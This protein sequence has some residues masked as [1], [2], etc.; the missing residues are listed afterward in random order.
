[1]RR[2]FIPATVVTAVLATAAA[3][4]AAVRT[5]STVYYCTSNN[6]SV[7]TVALEPPPGPV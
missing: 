5:V 3:A 7:T 1:M 6:C 4:T 2:I